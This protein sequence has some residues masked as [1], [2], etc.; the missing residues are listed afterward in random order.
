M[1][2]QLILSKLQKQMEAIHH[3]LTAEASE[4]ELEDINSSFEEETFR[5]S[6]SENTRHRAKIK[7]TQVQWWFAPMDSD[8]FQASVTK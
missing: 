3:E 4:E 7:F 8:T 1:L 6:P 5:L 2:K